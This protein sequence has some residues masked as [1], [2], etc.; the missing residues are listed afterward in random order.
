MKRGAIYWVNLEPSV[1]PELG[2][3]RPALVVSNTDQNEI[4]GSIVVV[5][6]SSQPNEIWPLRIELKIGKQKKSYA[7]IPGIRQ[8][9][10]SRIGKVITTLPTAQMDRVAE[11][12]HLYLG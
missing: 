7:V 8:V 4:L 11:A 3:V 6:L 10:K 1:N 5:P 12:I 2:K 9:S